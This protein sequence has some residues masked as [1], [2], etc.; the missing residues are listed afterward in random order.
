MDSFHQQR[1]SQGRRA[2]RLWSDYCSLLYLGWQREGATSVAENER[3]VGW[4]GRIS[5]ELTLWT[6]KVNR[7]SAAV[8]GE[9]STTL[10][11][12]PRYWTFGHLV[13][14]WWHC[15]RDLQGVIS[16]GEAHCWG[17]GFDNS[18]S[19]LS[20]EFALLPSCDSRV[21]MWDIYIFNRLK[22]KTFI[23][24]LSQ[25][26]EFSEVPWRSLFVVVGGLLV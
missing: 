14:S 8:V 17:A 2:S 5:S 19:T 24:K 18:E 4:W 26:D 15:L 21:F 13:P 3:C 22:A 6:D 9:T 11:M 20:R 23:R 12:S 16:M 25:R 7:K 1:K 10:R